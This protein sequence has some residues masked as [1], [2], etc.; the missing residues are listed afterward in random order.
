VAGDTSNP[1]IW[2]T[3]DVYRAPIG[4][5]APTDVVTAWD[6]A[7]KALGLVSE[8]DG[9][10]ESREEDLNDFYAYGGIL[11][12]TARSKHKRTFKVVAL[13]DN[14]IVWG[15]VNPGSTAATN[16]GVTTRTI[17]VPTT[18]FWAFGFHFTDG[19]ITKRL[20]IP[21]GQIVTVGEAQFMDSDM[22]KRELTI[23]IIPSA[24]R[25]LYYEIT[26]DPQAVAA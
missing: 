15:L 9:I 16:T 10:V 13:E 8:D 19:S 12:R 14:P 25:V 1:R 5:T 18:E 2:E 7:Y 6:G 11:I 22:L 17:K 20:A 4:S 24:S 21:R 3:A 26:D 23:N